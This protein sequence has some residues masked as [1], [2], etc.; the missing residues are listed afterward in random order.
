MVCETSRNLLVKVI[1]SFYLE[2]SSFAI[3]V[4]C[5]KPIFLRQNIN[6]TDEF[7]APPVV[8][9]TAKRINNDSRLSGCDAITAWVEV[10]LFTNLR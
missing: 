10:K 6:F 2:F 3:Q 4:V 1:C 8:I 7:Y 9:V 5:N